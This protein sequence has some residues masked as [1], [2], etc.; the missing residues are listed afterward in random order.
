MLFQWLSTARR[1][2]WSVNLACCDEP[3]L[4]AL[5]RE[6][7]FDPLTLDFEDERH[8]SRRAV[9]WRNFLR[10]W[11]Q[12]RLW[13]DPILLAPGAMPTGLSHL[14]ACLLARRRVACYV[15]LGH[16]SS[17][18]GATRP[19]LRDAWT[20]ACAA[21]VSLWITISAVQR[22]LLL[23]YWKVRAPVYVI[24][25]WLQ[26]P[27]AP[28]AAE[29]ASRDTLRV[30]YLGRFDS[31]QKG[32]DWLRH[33][34]ASSVVTRSWLQLTLQGQGD[35][36]SA[37]RQLAQ[38]QPQRI[39]LRHWSSSQE[40]LADCDALVLTSRFEGFPLVAVEAL[41]AGKPVMASDESGLKEILPDVCCF[42]FGDDIGFWRA[43]EH[44][45]DPLSRAAVV[46]H[47]REQL[48]KLLDARAFEDAVARVMCELTM[49]S[50]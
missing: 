29:F 5:A 35:D 30:L 40:A 12:A 31:H 1:L 50:A 4:L 42:A 21:R 33:L 2:G 36:E 26:T 6:A 38:A 48:D 22:R 32:L 34:L 11:R 24:P 27:A 19:R 39:R 44:L 7:G 47:G 17:V 43:A 16:S 13:R 10:T 23:E 46:A 14:L 3:A 15:P 25:N 41:R 45:R 18:L 49:N 20:R 9:Q 8:G 37:L 28:P